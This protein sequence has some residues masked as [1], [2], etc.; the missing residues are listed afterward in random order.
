M[1]VIEQKPALIL[2][3]TS[4]PQV[5]ECTAASHSMGVIEQ[6]PA[7]ILRHTSPPQ[8]HWSETRNELLHSNAAYI[9]TH[10]S[11]AV[12]VPSDFSACV[13][14]CFSRTLFCTCYLAGGHAHSLCMHTASA[15][16][17]RAL[18]QQL[19]YAA[20]MHDACCSRPFPVTHCTH[21]RTRARA[22]VGH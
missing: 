9:C 16:L 7:L 21:T 1:G 2:R 20:C 13:A 17:T 5:L 22:G 10:C 3:H 15:T 14:Q 8:V 4:P 19:L 12:Q 6:K 11:Q 18:L